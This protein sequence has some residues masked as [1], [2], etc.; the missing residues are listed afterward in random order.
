MTETP[1]FSIVI[2]T[3]NHA[4]LLRRCLDSIVFQTYSNWEVIVVNNF[5][6]DNTIEVVESY[7]D[8]RIH[9]INNSNNGIIAV[10][11][12][13]GISESQGEWICF[14]DSDDWWKHN[15]LE[16]CLPYLKDYDFIYHDLCIFRESGKKYGSRSV[17]AGR[18]VN[19]ESPIADVFINGNPIFNSTV[20]LR[21]TVID[22]VGHIT[23]QQEFIAV[24]D[25]DYWIRVMLYTKKHKYISQLLGYYYIGGNISASLKQIDR[26]NALYEKYKLTLTSFEQERTQLY[27]N[28][29]FARIYHMNGKFDEAKIKYIYSIKERYNL[30]KSIIGC[31][32][33]ILN[34]KY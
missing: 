27:L 29:Y 4:H 3:Y 21:K 16:A 10:S 14:L 26:L 34:R 33:L 6:E 11:R 32:L 22:A 28:Y 2:P 23:E 25:M 17:L 5:S 12:N 7:N 31:I 20:V 30:V 8:S 18:S 15:K 19:P 13:K 24:E 9:L 1:L